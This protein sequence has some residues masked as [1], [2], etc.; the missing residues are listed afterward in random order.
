MRILIL[1]QYLP[2]DESPTARLAGDV[3]EL[4]RQRG[5]EVRCL[6]TARPY[7]PGGGGLI[8]W[9]RD[10]GA[11][12]EL[13]VRAL[14][15]SPRPE[16]ILA[17]SSPPCL[18]V[19]AALAAR[20][21]R[22]HLWH[23]AMDVYP[24]TA[25]ALGVL[26][27]WL[28]AP[29]AGAMHAAYRA[30][31]RLVAL[32]EDMAAILRQSGA[33]VSG[34]VPPWPPDWPAPEAVQRPEGV[35]AEARIWMYSGN[36]G[37]AHEIETLLL[38]QHCLE[39]RGAPWWLVI[40]GAGAGWK[41]GRQRSRELG[42][43]QCQWRP[44]APEAEAAARLAAADVLV[45]TRRPELRGLLWPSKLAVALPV[46]RRVVWIGDKDSAVARTVQDRPGSAVLEPTEAERLADWLMTLPD[47]PLPA[48]PPDALTI[49]RDAAQNRWYAVML[50]D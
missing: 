47:G 21:H 44:Y 14:R 40:Q 12:L 5:H 43:R 9:A 15:E 48:I 3:A 29:L 10:I 42:L 41:S 31:A 38:A 35:P 4:L 33:K 2:P 18:L 46:P 23:W 36:L 27:G 30:C 25:V 24:Q 39:A 17:F 6:G 45:A 20:W 34:V 22:A 50:G 8:R 26:P 11:W 16:S 37:R 32:D 28:A 13:L 1:N 19:A 7:Q 49:T